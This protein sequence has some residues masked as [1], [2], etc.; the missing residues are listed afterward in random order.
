MKPIIYSVNLPMSHV[1]YVGKEMRDGRVIAKIEI[2][3]LHFEGDPYDH[4][5]GRDANGE[6]IFA[7][8][9][10]T[11]LYIEYSKP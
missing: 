11:E 10:T 2:E 6:I 1:D 5:V 4:Y 3:P 7:T 9:C 8:K